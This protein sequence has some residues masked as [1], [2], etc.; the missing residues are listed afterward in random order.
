VIGCTIE[1]N[2][3]DAGAAIYFVTYA[4]AVTRF[5]STVI[6]GNQ[7]HSPVFFGTPE[8]VS[9]DGCTITANTATAEGGNFVPGTAFTNSIVWGNFQPGGRGQASYSDVQGGA[10][11]VGN[12]DADPLFIRNPSPGADGQWGTADDDYGDLRLQ[13]NSPCIDAGSNAL[14]PTGVTTDIAGNPRIVDVPNVRDY[15]AVVDMGAYETQTSV[16]YLF[17]TPKPTIQV[18]FGVDINPATLQVGDLTLV[19]VV[20]GVPLNLG[21]GVSV[22]YDSASRIASWVFAS[23]L[24]DGDYRATLAAGNVTDTLGAPLPADLIGNAYVL[25]GDANRDRVVDINDLAI[26]AMNWKGGGKV[27]SQGDFNYDGKVNSADLGILSM[28]W[29]KVPLSPPPA[30]PVSIGNRAPTRSAT[31]VAKLVL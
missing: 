6:V 31:R 25:G 21:S 7:A 1:G 29:Q 14:L 23:P 22:S 12:I 3:G 10:S 11:G 17:D 18:S 28:N 13:P 24:P 16:N 19:N 26:L 4:A 2:T 20:S 9:F 27:F 5:L 30:A 15:G 8:H